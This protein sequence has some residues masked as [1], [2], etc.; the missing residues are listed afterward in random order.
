MLDSAV[1]AEPIIAIGETERGA[2]YTPEG[3]ADWVAGLVQAELRMGPATVVDFACG[4]GA[5]LAA[6]GRR[7][8]LRL[9]G[10]DVS[11]A[12]LAIAAETVSRAR[13]IHADALV[14]DDSSRL[15]D[16]ASK[17]IGIP[18]VDG[19][20]L[21]PPWGIELPHSAS[22]LRQRGYRLAQGH[23]DSAGLFV[24]LAL[25]A[26]APGGVAGLI[27]PDSIFF[28]GHS[29]L[30]KL[31]VEE[32]ELLLLARLGEGFFP[33]VF[34]GTAVVVLRKRKPRAGHEVACMALSADDRRAV[35]A[36]Q[37]ALAAVAAREAHLV[38]QTRFANATSV[39]FDIGV[40]GR[41][42]AFVD[43]MREHSA[44]WSHWFASGRGVELSKH[45]GVVTCP[46]CGVSRPAPRK[47]QVVGCSGCGLVSE[48]D[49]LRS[50]TIVRPLTER[51]RRWAPLIG[52]DDVG[53]YRA[54]PSREIRTGVA[55]INYKPGHDRAGTR[56]L[57]R[58]TGIGLRAALIDRP[59]HTTQVV[60]HYRL[61]QDA[62]PFFAH[63]VLGLLCSRTLL[64]FHL[65]RS[66]ETQWRSHPYVTQKV[67]DALPIPVPSLGTAEWARAQ[68]IAQLA[69][70]LMGGSGDEG[71]DYQLEGLVAGLYGLTPADIA[72]IS[73]VLDDA[74]D[75]DG[76][77]E[78]R[79]GPGRIAPVSV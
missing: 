24:E 45:G 30:R 74:Q 70:D 56:I 4:Q 57:V 55:G 68:S 36:G 69:K 17:A 79:F 26:L 39:D 44:N 50:Q 76:I 19:I 14:P 9:V 27:L 52:G 77:R 16:A 35:L 34:R 1:R 22:A 28:P 32:A 41:H 71:L 64:A 8:G 75:L 38:P 18:R 7:R 62:P 61:D 2:I 67:I 21:N 23:F 60:F 63:Y 54:A 40:R 11:K 25:A 43:R 6:L 58:K 72:T 5:L 37:T 15:P 10:V 78:L 65:L 13:L 12:D 3:L 48:L 29:P 59:A 53:R 46:A 49:D 33:G 20:V 66:G 31:L 73:G 42:V 47:L 51:G